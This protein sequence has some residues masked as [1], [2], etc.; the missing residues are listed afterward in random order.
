M[1]IELS[2]YLSGVTIVRFNPN[3]RK[4]E[5]TLFFAEPDAEVELYSVFDKDSG[6]MIETNDADNDECKHISDTTLRL[7]PYTSSVFNDVIPGS[8][9]VM[10]SEPTDGEKDFCQLYYDIEIADGEGFHVNKL[11]YFKVDIGNSVLP[12]SYPSGKLLM[13]KICYTGKAVPLSDYVA[14]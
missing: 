13:N 1:N 10:I 8:D 2:L 14:E 5:T 4:A 9:S 6:V 11:S 7:S 12:N 3:S